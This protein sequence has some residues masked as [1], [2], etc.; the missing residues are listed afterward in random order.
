MSKAISA[1]N[2][3]RLGGFVA[4]FTVP[5]DSLASSIG[6][7]GSAME[8][9]SPATNGARRTRAHSSS[10]KSLFVVMTSPPRVNR[11]RQLA[12]HVIAQHAHTGLPTSPVVSQHRATN[13]DGKGP[14]GI[15]MWLCA[16]RRWRGG[17]G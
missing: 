7:P 5:I 12:W 14:F 11:R 8:I 4:D 1:I 9:A 15:H 2:C 17:D 10:V 6:P 16:V 13:V 3:S